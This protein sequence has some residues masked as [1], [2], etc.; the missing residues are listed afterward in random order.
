ME[1]F[2]GLGQGDRFP[3]Q[4]RDGDMQVIKLPVIHGTTKIRKKTEMYSALSVFALSGV[5][6]VGS[7]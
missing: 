1:R 3:L 7:M 2:V 6:I 4:G 5:L